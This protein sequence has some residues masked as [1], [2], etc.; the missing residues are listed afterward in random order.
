M[1]VEIGQGTLLL[2]YA[3]N[4]TESA[5]PGDLVWVPVRQRLHAGLV[6]AERPEPPAGMPREQ[7][8][9]VKNL[10]LKGAFS[11]VWHQMIGWCAEQT[12]TSLLQVLRTA[13]PPGVLGQRAGNHNP[14]KGRRQL[15]V[16]RQPHSS[17]RQPARLD[18]TERQ[19]HLLQCLD[20]H[21]P[22]G[23]W[24][25]DLLQDSGCSRGPVDNLARAGL[26][27][28]ESRHDQAPARP[29]PQPPNSDTLP[30][31]PRQLTPGQARVL[32]SLTAPTGQGGEVLL[33]GI[34]GSGKTEIYLQAAAF[35]LAQGRDVLMLCPEIGLIPQL[36][37]RCRRRFPDR[38][39]SYSSHLSDGERRQTWDRC[40][41]GGP[42]LV[43]GTRSAVFLPLALLGLAVLDEEHDPSYK[44]EAPMPCYHARDVA[45]YRARQAG[46]YLLLGSATPSLESWRRC[47]AGACQLLRLKERV[48]GGQLPAIRVV[49]MRQELA[50]GQ[51]TAIS[52][53][54]R[55]RLEA[56]C[57]RGEQA[58]LFVPRRGYSPFLNCRSC[59]EAVMCPHC[60]LALTVH[61]HH[62]SG[63]RH[64][65]LRCH[66]CN[67]RQPL[68]DRCHHC[69]SRAFKPFGIGTQR[70]VELL[71]QQLPGLRLLRYDHDT[72][73]GKDGHR[74]ILE[75]F[76]RHQADVLVGTQMLAK[77]MDLPNVTMAV[78]LAADGLMYRPDLRAQE[79]A[80]QVF[81]Q[82]AGRAGRGTKP[83]EVLVQTYAPE[84]VVVRSLVEGSYDRFLNQEMESRRRHGLAPYVRACL[85]RLSGPSARTTANG[86]ALLA[87][88]LSPGLGCQGWTVVGPAPA[89]VA[90]VAQRSRW[91][92]LLHGPEGPLPLPSGQNLRA[93]LPRGVDLTI[94]PDPMHL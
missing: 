6:M 17:A 1:L 53:P 54:L 74:R 11:R 3:N 36:L 28:L 45:R 69:G 13:L 25:K 37:D 61:R 82:L 93:V 92:L 15:W 72:T 75:Q 77:G 2:T 71:Q 42:W 31:P 34:T 43:V 59:G 48:A 44:Q 65:V 51:R 20:R 64:D 33:W 16:Q 68:Q 83:G 21:G 5:E 27:A 39:L 19:H 26:L 79:Q 10:I 22:Q 94:D 40:R 66:W 4:P 57:G 47:Q 49:D 91:Q 63:A 50:S 76:A 56:V 52:R 62:N 29:Q 80:L 41:H 58:V 90:R 12:H 46:A 87:S 30:E 86:A 88:H 14:R 84:H 85:L 81:F 35:W 70:V 60:A 38:V 9:T 78:V 55:D 89:P 73:R 7:L 8:Q 24:L 23:C 32:A 67:H 18:V